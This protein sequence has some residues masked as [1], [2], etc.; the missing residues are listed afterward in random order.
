MRDRERRGGRRG[1]RAR[2]GRRRLGGAAGAGGGQQQ[3][4]GDR[5]PSYARH[6]RTVSPSL[7]R[8]S[9]WGPYCRSV[10]FPGGPPAGPVAPSHRE[11][12]CRSASP[13]SPPPWPRCSPPPRS[14]RPPPHRPRWPRRTSP[15]TAVKAHL[16]Q[17]QTIATANGG[18]RA[19]GRP[20]YLA[21]VNYV[22]RPARRG[23]LH[24]R[25]AV[26]HLQRRDRLQPDRR[27]AGRRHQRHP[28][29]RRAPRQ[30][31]R[32]AGHQRQRLR[33][34]R[35]SSR[36]RSPSRASGFQPDAG[37]CA[38]AGGAPRSWG[39]AARRLYVNSLPRRRAGEDQR[40]PQ[41]RHGRL[42]Q[43]RLLPLR[44]RQ[45][46]R[47]RLRPRPGRLGRDREHDRRRTSP[48]I[49]VPTRG[50]DFDGRSDYGPFIAAGIPAGGTFTGAE[51]S[52]TSAQA[53]L[54]GGTAGSA[55]DACYHRSCDTTTNINDTALDRNADAIAYAV[56]TLAERRPRRRRPRS[57]RTPSRRRPAGPP[58]RAAPTPPPPGC[59]QRGDPA[60][61][62]S[63]VATQLGTTV[64]G[65]FDLVTGAT[66]GQ[67]ARAPTTST[68][69]SPRS[70]R[71]RSRCPTGTLT[72]SFS[73]YLAHLTNSS[74]ADYFRVS[75]GLRGDGDDG[76]HP[77]RR[78]HQ[79]G[80]GVG[81]RRR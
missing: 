43:P 35:R 52:K 8:R 78:G 20:G 33:L 56:W 17:L 22:Q 36:S 18:N 64:S 16:T 6:P 15:S 81:D 58:T 72:L 69:A 41:L 30:R 44:R 38:S 75:G 25:G 27:L 74:S 68:A 77:G 70:S 31:H 9:A 47:H 23:R 59:S 32:R 57:T 80:R 21:S 46:R 60:A 24:H 66:R 50:T 79:P 37:T 3:H 42:A 54:W 73:W 53:Q 14:R 65:T 51:G 55:F 28:D 26:V 1:A 39:C 19:H 4:P 67:P 61:T 2:R 62:S 11:G 40:L 29:D 34:G 71:R 5:D 13:C 76:L 49:G 45:L 12:P 63:G 48:S 7:E 10:R